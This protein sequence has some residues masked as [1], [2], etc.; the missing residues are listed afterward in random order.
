MQ[1]FVAVA[2][3]E[4]EGLPYKEDEVNDDLTTIH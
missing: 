2:E 4:E 3:L 1:G